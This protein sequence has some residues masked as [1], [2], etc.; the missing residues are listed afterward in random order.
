MEK[1]GIH[2][3]KKAVVNEEDRTF[4]DME[5]RVFPIE[6]DLTEED[7]A[8]LDTMLEEF[9]NFAKEKAIPLAIYGIRANHEDDC[10]G[11]KLVVI[12]GPRANIKFRCAVE[13]ANKIIDN[14]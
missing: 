4:T 8:K 2:I 6:F 3:V 1:E 9:A 12:S 11:F 7:S 14:D 5:G 13:L 10:S